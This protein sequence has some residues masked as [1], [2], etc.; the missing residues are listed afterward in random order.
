M[1]TRYRRHIAAVMFAFLLLHQ[2][3]KLLIAPLTT[4]IMEDFNIN[5]GLMGAVLPPASERHIRCQVRGGGAIDY[6]DVLHNNRVIHRACKD[7]RTNEQFAPL[8]GPLKIYLEL[9]WGKKGGQCRLASRVAGCRWRF[10]RCG[11]ALS[12]S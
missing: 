6:V 9:G 5:D 3:D 7:F 8:A 2:A 10:A 11:A 12:R 4:A 1:K